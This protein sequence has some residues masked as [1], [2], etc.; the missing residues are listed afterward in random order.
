MFCQ[1]KLVKG[2]L[3]RLGSLLNDAMIYR[4]AI[5][6]KVQIIF[7]AAFAAKNIKSNSKAKIDRLVPKLGSSPN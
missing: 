3:V 6:A 5:T 4:A 7:R 1:L 2:L